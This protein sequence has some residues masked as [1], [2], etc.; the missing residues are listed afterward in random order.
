IVV[1]GNPPPKRGYFY[2]LTVIANALDGMRVVKEEQFGPV[3]PVVKYKTVEE[4]IERASS[5]E[6]GLGGSVWGDDPK[7]AA[8]YERLLECVTAWVNQRGA[9]HP[10]GPF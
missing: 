1:G 3:I 7:E 10:M 6:V 2:P 9:L 5:L 8:E 4:A